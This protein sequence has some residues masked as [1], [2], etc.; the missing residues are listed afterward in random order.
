MQGE[1]ALWESLLGHLTRNWIHI[2]IEINFDLSYQDNDGPIHFRAKNT[3]VPASS[4][5]YQNIRVFYIKQQ[6]LPDH[7]IH[8]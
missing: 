1:R 6:Y 3:D 7:G 8:D 4:I 2:R 5:H